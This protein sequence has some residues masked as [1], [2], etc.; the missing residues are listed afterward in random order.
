MGNIITF[1][2]RWKWPILWVGFF[3]ILWVLSKSIEERE[4]IGSLPWI[5]IFAYLLRTF[6]ELI[7]FVIL[8]KIIFATNAVVNS[9]GEIFSRVL[10]R[11]EFLKT[12]DKTQLKKIVNDLTL[13]EPDFEVIDNGQKNQAILIAKKKWE[14]KKDSEKKPY[15]YLESDTNTT[16][17]ENGQVIIYKR[18]KV[19]MM[20]TSK[21][22]TYHGY[23]PY[24][25]KISSSDKLEKEEYFINRPGNRWNGKSYKYRVYGRDITPFEPEVSIRKTKKLND[26]DVESDTSYI[27]FDVVS[28]E[29]I[30]KGK[31]FIIEYSIGDKISL[32]RDE[33]NIKRRE[34]YFTEAY[35]GRS[36]PTAVRN[37]TFQLES[38]HDYDTHK[39]NY[40]PIIE[41]E[42]GDPISFGPCS[43]T[44]YYRK[45]THTKYIDESKKHRD[46]TIKLVSAGHNQ[47]NC[48]GSVELN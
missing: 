34:E 29:L 37:I 16:L 21:F 31:I 40:V 2:R 45:W 32:E 13:A 33:Y 36:I 12:L 27:H 39:L 19:L 5:D 25:K 8:M 35:T 30:E 47:V 11:R 41:Y 43:E 23:I 46:Y 4:T 18:F 6:S 44:I 20:E 38:Y 3:S 42:K 7:I 28:S 14:E 9:M 48:N 26:N 24:D 15:I 1:I 17:Y 22:T 10:F